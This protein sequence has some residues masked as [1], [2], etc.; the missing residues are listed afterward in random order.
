MFRRCAIS[1]ITGMLLFSQQSLAHKSH[2]PKA[3]PGQ[4]GQH[5]QGS[6]ERTSDMD[7]QT[8]EYYFEFLTNLAYHC[9]TELYEQGLELGT[10]IYNHLGGKEKPVE[11]ADL[12]HRVQ[13]FYEDL[14]TRYAVVK[15]AWDE[16]SL[17]LVGSQEP[18]SVAKRIKHYILIE[19]ENRTDQPLSLTA[20]ALKK[21][22]WSTFSATIP[23]GKTRPMITS[24]FVAGGASPA[25]VDISLVPDAND[26]AARTVAIPVTITIP[27]TI[28]GKLIDS[29][30]S[31]IWPGRVFVVASDNFYH[32]GKA[33]ADNS[34]L[35]EK[36]LLQY[37]PIEKYYKLQCFY[38]DGTFEIDVPSGP[39]KIV[40]ERGFE[41]EVVTEQLDLLPGEVREITLKSSRVIDMKKLGW[42]SGDTHIHWAKN[43]WSEEEDIELLA[44]VQRAEDLRFANN[45]T[46]RH[47]MPPVPGF[48]GPAQFPMGPVPGLCDDKYHIQMAEEYRNNDFYGHLC[49]LNIKRIVEP[50]STGTMGGGADA[51][52]YPINKTAILDCHSQGGIVTEA[53]DLGS[54]NWNATIDV[55]HGLA[56]CMDQIHPNNYYMLLDCG[57]KIPLGNG[58]DHPARVIGCSRV[59]VKV[60]GKFTYQK[61]INGIRKR[62]TFTTSGPLIFLTV[63]NAEI[64]DELNL[65]KGDML[66]VKAKVF[67]RYPVGKFQVV[68]NDGEILKSVEV[69]GNNAEINLRLPADKSR[70]FVARCAQ[71]DYYHSLWFPNIAH[72]SAVY[73]TVDGEPIL[74]AETLKMFIER[75]KRYARDVKENA[76][77]AN[78]EQR[79]EAVGYIE[80]GVEKFEQLLKQ[81]E[82]LER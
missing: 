81:A 16:D 8:F 28:K 39:V 37:P 69:P 61:W 79:K 19:V 67:S 20:S 60:D 62:S 10:E 71:K 32:H 63:N 54:Q 55:V 78:N 27:A 29:Q 82:N 35:S 18:I 44:M 53:H 76:H 65:S 51:P 36:Q 26:S 6:D 40:M 13:H 45:L 46:L 4:I 47:D 70:W 15:L 30:T 72:T 3:L 14:Q 9:P 1:L 58:S 49:F 22:N 77:F 66:S 52:D 59:Y 42:I 7:R 24:L 41:H 48:I 31:K 75:G 74:K 2:M 43:W 56:D 68:S 80:Q 11:P 33:Y 12:A 23:A 64:G 50:I 25:A 17:Q 5:I 34:T 38:S 57:F 73:V 21:V